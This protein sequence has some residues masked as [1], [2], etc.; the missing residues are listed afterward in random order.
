MNPR[1]AN[2]ANFINQRFKEGLP[3]YGIRL[4][5]ATLPMWGNPDH[6]DLLCDRAKLWVTYFIRCR[7]RAYYGKAAGRLQ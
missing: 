2:I 1:V 3:Y 5:K 4:A 7:L 6:F